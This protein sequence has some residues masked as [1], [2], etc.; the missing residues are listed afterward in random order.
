MLM[1]GDSLSGAM[2]GSATKSDM[3]GPLGT[4]GPLKILKRSGGCIRF[5]NMKLLNGGQRKH[6]VEANG[7]KR[8]VY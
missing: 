3:F 7:G 4:Q 8:G 5:R 2:K 1:I 6:P